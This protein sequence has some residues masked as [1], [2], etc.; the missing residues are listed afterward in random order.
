[1]LNAIVMVVGFVLLFALFFTW[2]YNSTNPNSAT[3]LATTNI[4]LLDPPS[5]IDGVTLGPNVSVLLIGQ[6]QEK[7]RGLYITS[8]WSLIY[9]STQPQTF[10]ILQGNKFANTQSY[11]MPSTPDSD[12]VTDD[13]LQGQGTLA[14]PLGFAQN[15]AT[16]GDVM[17]FDGTNWKG[18]APVEASKS[19]GELYDSWDTGVGV[20]AW[21]ATSGTISYD[22]R[23]YN[24]SASAAIGDSY[25]WTMGSNGTLP[26]VVGQFYRFRFNVETANNR[27]IANISVDNTVGGQVSVSYVTDWYQATTTSMKFQITI[28]GKDPG[29]SNFLFATTS[30]GIDVLSSIT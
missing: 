18:A 28:T 24:T 15:G 25:E 4:N 20:Q 19:A 13:T 16:A 30:L 29:S 2:P 26:S 10:T 7:E 17:T 1:M 21:A 9:R 22:G 23:V 11:I 3:L 6:I 5:E 8:P 27:A 12:I 14:A